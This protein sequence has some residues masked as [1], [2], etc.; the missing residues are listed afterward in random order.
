MDC[1][2]QD[3]ASTGM[4]YRGHGHHTSDG[5]VDCP[6]ADQ[7]SDHTIYHAMRGNNHHHNQWM[8]D[9]DRH[10]PFARGDKPVNQ[11]DQGLRN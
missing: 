6:Y 7:M 9:R 5:D 1:P 11:E 2:C 4:M 3:E 8:E 10:C